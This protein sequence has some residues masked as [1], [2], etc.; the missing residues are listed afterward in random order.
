[1]V[2]LTGCTAARAA[3]PAPA[4]ESKVA[5]P[6]AAV[7]VVRTA[8]DLLANRIHAS[9]HRDGH[10]V[11][12]AGGADFYKYADGGWKTSWF[13]DDKDEGQPAALVAGLS[14]Q[15][16]VPLDGDAD[17]AGAGGV[18]A[19]TANATLAFTVRP[20]APKQKLSLFV[21]EKAAGTLDL[22]PARKRYEVPVP[23]ALLRPGEN[24]LRFTFKAAGNA[25][26]GSKAKAK[27]ARRSAA[28]VF[29]VSLGPEAAGPPPPPEGA[30]VREVALAGTRKRA[31][32]ITTA[33][34]K[35]SRLSYY[36]QPPAGSSLVLAIGAEATA[37][38]RAV[39]RVAIDGQPPKQLLDVVAGGKWTDVTLPLGAAAGQAARIDLVSRGGTVLWAEPRLVVDAPPPPSPA[40]APATKIEHMFVWMVDT[41]RADKVRVYNPKTRVETPNYDAFAADATRF[42]WAQVPGTWSLPSHASLLT[43]VYPSVHKATAHEGRLAAEVPFIAE[44]LKKKGFKTAIFSSNGYVSGKWGFERGW[45]AYRN[46][47]RENMPNGADHLWKTAKTWVVANQKSPQFVYLATVEPHVIYNPKPQFLA[48]Y[49]K[50]PY[51][52][53]IKPNQSGVQLGLIKS[54]KLKVTDNDH[55]YLEAL[56]D[57]EIT[58]SDAAFAT[59][60]ADLKTAGLYDKSVVIVVSDHGDE[61]NEHGGLGHGHS[62]YQEL[63]RIPLIIR[64]PGL[65]PVGRVVEGDVEVMDLYPTMLQ[66]LGQTA[67]DD[68]QG[69]SLVSLAWDEVGQT[70]RAALTMD[71]QASR[72][73]KVARYRLV[74]ASGKLELYDEIDD[75]LE[76][77]DVAGARPIALR[78][79][80]GVLGLLHPYE[81]R[82]SKTRWG[83]AANIT[84]A[85]AKDLGL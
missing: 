64:A 84:A 22:E 77:K 4:G 35:A 60:I 58:Q 80:R 7:L 74:A 10:L 69:S 5:A 63:T 38:V 67:G 66:L 51:K 43:G 36:L 28:A 14:G 79:M 54:G 78:Q 41:L 20:L 21:N 34:G 11:I 8:M 53:P 2:A 65:L 39:V 48:K 49:W 6:P 31:V 61:F 30:R 32:T 17:G 73:L 68:I 13:L 44:E 50:K 82:W 33:A 56:H 70:P 24:R 1:M 59:F 25:G 19:A 42:A 46:F 12:E 55:A 37:G 23:A 26:T 18:E 16:F 40:P 47:I 81:S 75:R 57:A 71:G 72:G 76:Q 29:D 27:T 62:V 45:D 85:A 3:P 52:G 15:M 83:T 9:S